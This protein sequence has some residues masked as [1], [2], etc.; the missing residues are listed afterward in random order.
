M[1]FRL[2]ARLYDNKVTAAPMALF[3]FC[4]FLVM[5]LEVNNLYFFKELIFDH[6]PFVSIG[7]LQP[8]GILI[9]WHFVLFFMMIGYKFK[10]FAW[11]NYFLTIV[12]FTGNHEFEYHVYYTYIGVSLFSLVIPMAQVMSVDNLLER[13]KKSRIGKIHKPVNKISVLSYHLPML[14]GVGFVYLDSIFYKFDTSLYTEGLG[15]WLPS[16]LPQISIS[17]G[18]LLNNEFIVKG[19]GFLT[20]IFE[21]LFVFTFWKEKFK[22]V[23]LVI[24]LG[25]H[26]GILLSFPIPLFANAVVAM[27]ILLIPFDWVEKAS[28]SFKN[29]RSKR[30]PKI[31]VFFDAECPLCLRTRIIIEYIDIFNVVKF[32]SAQSIPSEDHL[33][34]NNSQ[35]EL[36]SEIFSIKN[37]KVYKGVN[38]YF[39]IFKSLHIFFLL[40]LIVILPPFKQLAGKI[41][42]IVANSRSTER[43]T[44][45]SCGIP[46][47]AVQE[48]KPVKLFKNL[49]VRELKIFG[50]MTGFIVLLFFQLNVSI[51]SGI[52]RPIT[53]KVFE[54]VGL[55]KHYR[56][57]QQSI[58]EFSRLLTGITAHPVFMNDH[59]DDYNNIYAI[60]YE[61]D[62]G[63]REFLP[64]INSEGSPGDYNSGFIWVQWSWRVTGPYSNLAQ[65]K[66]GIFNYSTFWYHKNELQEKNG[67]FHVLLKKVEIPTDWED[68]F[69]QKQR[70]K[71]WEEIGSFKLENGKNFNL[72]LNE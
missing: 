31:E 47:L 32:S 52:L 25:L 26:F 6:I 40:Y 11:I 71:E 3:R 62:N 33:L 43:C 14:I 1:L 24:G 58:R 51:N 59:F 34:S 57:T 66:N 10:L 13:I 70:L 27:Y 56:H 44:E 12:F 48:E 28:A 67:K 63:E 64:I 55:I 16:S 46:Q 20:V 7:T 21:L 37:G 18:L 5:L 54:K 15:V 19:L 41:Y 50:A 8:G 22:P 29:W 45:E 42:G 9:I 69:L 30:T 49:S 4:F 61:H 36:F 60:V 17:K 68:D 23:I 39:Q 72:N 35:D 53:T 2:F 65:L 38:T